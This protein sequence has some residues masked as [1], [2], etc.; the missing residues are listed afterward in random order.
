MSTTIQEPSHAERLE[1]VADVTVAGPGAADKDHGGDPLSEKQNGESS[2]PSSSDETGDMVQE[3]PQVPERSKG[4]VALIMGSLCVS[5]MRPEPYAAHNADC[6][7]QIAVF[8]AALDTVSCLVGML[9]Y[10]CSQ[11]DRQLLPPPFP[12]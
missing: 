3:K 1:A 11:T 12:L 10:V 2:A 9:D 8:L 6:I 4:K 7:F 5:C